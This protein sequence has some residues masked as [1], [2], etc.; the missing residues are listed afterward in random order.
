MRAPCATATG[1]DVVYRRCDEDRLFD[2][3]GTQTLV[4]ERLLEP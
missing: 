3:H 1:I 2:E 4:A